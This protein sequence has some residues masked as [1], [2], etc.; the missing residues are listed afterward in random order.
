MEWFWDA[1]APN[2]AVRRQVLAS[3]LRAA[4]VPVTSVHFPEV[5]NDFMMLN[6][7]RETAAARTATRLAGTTLR[8]AL[9][10]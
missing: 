4:G 8:Q 1:Y 6:P 10:G 3:P 2:P 5:T 9:H 7:L